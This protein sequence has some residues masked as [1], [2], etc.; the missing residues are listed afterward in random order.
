MKI[1]LSNAA[2]KPHIKSSLLSTSLV[3]LAL[4]SISVLAQ[5]SDYQMEKKPTYTLKIVTHGEFDNRSDN[6]SEE[7]RQD[8]RRADVKMKASV[9]QGNRIVEEETVEEVKVKVSDAVNRSIKLADGGIIWISKDPASLTPT[10]NVTTS[11]RV[12][13]KSGTFESPVSFEIKT[14]YAHF[15]DSWELNVYRS[16]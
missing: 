4:C 3:G 15:I 1:K 12:E 14:N 7:S 10:L 2:M 13:M 11:Q 16:K 5:A 6:M 9:Q 8:N